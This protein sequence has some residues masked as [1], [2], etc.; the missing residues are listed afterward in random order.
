MVCF[1]GQPG[2]ESGK[3]QS[4]EGR[5]QIVDAESLRPVK[6]QSAFRNL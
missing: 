3:L 4:S 2:C 5:F 1:G 6:L